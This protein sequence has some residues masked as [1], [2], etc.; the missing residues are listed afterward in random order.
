MSLFISNSEDETLKYAAQFAQ[1][2]KQGDIVA[3]PWHL[4]NG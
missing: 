4:G 3:L 1:S 2:L